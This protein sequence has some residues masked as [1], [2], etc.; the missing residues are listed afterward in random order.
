MS[1]VAQS[2]IGTEIV[3]ALFGLARRAWTSRI[4]CTPSP[5]SLSAVQPLRVH[6]LAGRLFAP[7]PEI[8]QASYHSPTMSPLPSPTSGTRERQGGP[9]LS[10]HAAYLEGIAR[11]WNTF[12][13]TLCTPSSR[14]IA[15]R[16]LQAQ[17][18]APAHDP[19]VA[20]YFSQITWYHSVHFTPT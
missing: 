17:L 10:A 15:G 12:D 6:D 16:S 9:V 11:R 13:P 8:L 4:G 2:A 1:I 20:W 3:L 5:A 19:I 7:A 14:G 18:T